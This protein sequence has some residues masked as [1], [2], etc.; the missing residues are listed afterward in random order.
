MGCELVSVSYVAFL[1]SVRVV[2]RHDAIRAENGFSVRVQN[3]HDRDGLGILTGRG[4]FKALTRCEKGSAP[5]FRTRFV[6]S[7]RGETQESE[8]RLVRTGGNSDDASR[9]IS[10]WKWHCHWREHSFPPRFRQVFPSPDRDESGLQVVA[11]VLVHQAFQMALVENDH[12]VKQI[13][14][15]VADEAFGNAVLPWTPKA[16]LFALDAQA[17]HHVD[18][19]LVEAG[20]A[21]ENQVAGRGV[22][23]GRFAQLLHHP[24][25]R[26]MAGHV[27]LKNAPTVM[28]DDAE[29][30][31]H[32]ECRRR[33]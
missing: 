24:S 14:P 28:R 12:M 5:V 31:Q 6:R 15:T 19:P 11:G 16:G 26:W 30:I 29:A 7:L 13:A 21:I 23:R 9:A 1:A 4:S 18:H 10:A 25:A 33:H 17:P 22:I 8:E 3:D 20:A 27:E 32:A 2:P